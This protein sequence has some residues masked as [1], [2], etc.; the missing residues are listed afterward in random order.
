MSES[1]IRE[2]FK[3]L[4]AEEALARIPYFSGHYSVAELLRTRIEKE[5]KIMADQV[6]VDSTM[7][8]SVQPKTYKCTTCTRTYTQ[9]DAEERISNASAYQ[10]DECICG[11]NLELI[12]L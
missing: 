9:A 7:F 10:R 8:F 6:P 2:L 3:A 5:I 4:E 1:Y 11:G 12:P